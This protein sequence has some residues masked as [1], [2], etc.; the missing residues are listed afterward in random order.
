M[1]LEMVAPYIGTSSELIPNKVEA[2][3]IRRFAIASMETDPIYYDEEYA[4]TTEYGTIIAPPN[5]A[6]TFYIP[7]VRP[8]EGDM[9]PIRG[10]LHATQKYE[11]LKPIKAGDT[12][13][14]RSTLVSAREKQGSSG[15]LLF[16]TFEHAV[17]D[18]NGEAYNLGYNTSVYKEPLLKNKDPKMFTTYFPQIPKADWLESVGKGKASAVQ[19]GDKIGPL[20]FPEMNQTWVAQWAGATGDYNPIHLDAEAAK[21]SGMSGTIVHGMLSA[22]LTTR[23]FGYWLGS[24]ARI[25]K[26]NTKFAAPVVPGDRLVMQAEVTAVEA[27][28]QGVEVEWTY[29]VCLENGKA[30]LEGTM[31]GILPLDGE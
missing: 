22:T 11:Y 6:R 23:V 3:A 18:E 21:G 28:E 10:R 27:K 2:G 12:V 13:Y 16:L 24:S 17:L 14:F 20:Q 31:G 30:V 25:T 4:K 26:S 19:V 5:F 29:T 8:V 7:P 15:W 1:Y 9:L